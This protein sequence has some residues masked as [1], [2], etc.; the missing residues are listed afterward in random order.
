LTE[1][2][3]VL[4]TVFAGLETEKKSVGLAFAT[5]A[6][7]YLQT[8]DEGSAVTMLQQ[9]L[10][11]TADKPAKLRWHFLLGQLLQR[12][13]RREEAYAHYSRVVKS[14]APYELS[15]HAG[16]NRVFLVTAENASADDRV[17]LLRRM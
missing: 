3:L 4:D 11:H 7:Y 15:F 8:H 1:A 16:L 17:H 10:E 2:G 9:A 13:D 14:N 5:Q 12:L 6:Q